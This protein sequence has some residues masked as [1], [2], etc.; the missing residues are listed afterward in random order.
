MTHNWVVHHRIP[1]LFLKLYFK[2]AFDKVEHRYI[3]AVLEIVGLDGT[4]L[5]LVQGLFAGAVSKVH[6][7][8]HFTKEI[9]LTRG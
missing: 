5:K 3:W 4:F 9:P 8:G 2:K 7:N 1:T 6:I